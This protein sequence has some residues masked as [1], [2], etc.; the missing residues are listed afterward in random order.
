M[1]TLRFFSCSAWVD[2][3]TTVSN[4]VTVAS[5]N[6]LYIQFLSARGSVHRLPSPGPRSV[7]LEMKN[8]YEEIG[9]HFLFASPHAARIRLARKASRPPRFNNRLLKGISTGG[10]GEG[11]P[12]GSTSVTINSGSGIV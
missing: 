12:I 5:E 2:E 10:R 1:I 11:G 6:R 3:M 9:N 8:P 4:A 7:Y